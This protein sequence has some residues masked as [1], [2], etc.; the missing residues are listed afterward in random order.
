[1]FTFQ[2]LL[3]VILALSVVSFIIQNNT[4]QMSVVYIAAA[5]LS[6]INHVINDTPIKRESFTQSNITEDDLFIDVLFTEPI[7]NDKDHP[8]RRNL[9]LYVS[10]FNK[11]MLNLKNESNTMLNIINKNLGAITSEK[12]KSGFNQIHGANIERTVLL[13]TPKELFTDGLKFTIVVNMRIG[14]IPNDAEGLSFLKFDADN[15]ELFKLFDV[16]F[17]NVGKK[18][19]TIKIFWGTTAVIDYSYVE[20]DLNEGKLFNDYENHTFI[21]VKDDLK[22][23][24]ES[25]EQSTK[26]HM[27]GNIH[28]YMDGILMASGPVP[29]ITLRDDAADIALSGDN[30]YTKLNNGSANNTMQFSLAAFGIYDNRALTLTECIEWTNYINSVHIRLNPECKIL[31]SERLEEKLKQLNGSTCKV[32]DERICS[33]KCTTVTNW[34]NLESLTKNRDCFKAIVTYCD[35]TSNQN[36]K[37]FCSFLNRQGIFESASILDSNLLYYRNGSE[38]KESI[39]NQELLADLQKLGL[40]DVFIDKSFRSDATTGYTSEMRKLLRDLLETNQTVNVE[41]INKIQT[42]THNETNDDE[43]NNLLSKLKA[44]ETPSS[45]DTQTHRSNNGMSDL[46][47]L[48]I[49]NASRSDSYKHIIDQYNVDKNKTS[50][51]GMF[52]KMM[53]WF[54]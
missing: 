39:T 5:C 30:H 41:T 21:F 11:S 31:H 4:N 6:Y 17:Y 48:D 22:T 29:N 42:G 46:I 36:D 34:N 23:I 32:Q 44:S 38:N 8:L 26:A 13:Q 14:S 54:T 9:V 20:N 1:M 12:L 53:G 25:S 10:S 35:H 27:Y 18:N 15:S 49:A 37:D 43:I 45:H 24:G 19:P 50:D 16:R 47:D 7:L 40:K 28:F 33:E 51:S 52:G 3:Y 2:N